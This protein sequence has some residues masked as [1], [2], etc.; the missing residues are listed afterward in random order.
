MKSDNKIALGVSIVMM[1]M[2]A[3]LA[4]LNF[5]GLVP[6]AWYW[7][8]SPFWIVFGFGFIILALVIV[9]IIM[10][11]VAELIAEMLDDIFG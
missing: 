4:I 7:I 2:T 3:I 5:T 1:V 9:G 6:M 10:A 8:V 11:G